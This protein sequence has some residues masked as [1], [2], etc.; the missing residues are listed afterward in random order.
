MLCPPIW[1]ELRNQSDP[2]KLMV[3]VL[4]V[5]FGAHTFTYPT[6]PLSQEYWSPPTVKFVTPSN[7]KEAFP[8]I[9]DI[10]PLLPRAKGG[11]LPSYNAPDLKTQFPPSKLNAYP[12]TK[13]NLHSL[14]GACRQY[15]G[16]LL[17]I[18]ILLQSEIDSIVI[19]PKK[20]RSHTNLGVAM[21]KGS[22][23]PGHASMPLSARIAHKVTSAHLPSASVPKAETA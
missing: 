2:V 12:R 13:S 17:Y 19:K 23:G 14:A 10:C 5:G 15:I 3:S 4:G 1:I 11:T 16:Y 6:N 18:A 22:D 20:Y 21:T 8:L 9:V 7:V